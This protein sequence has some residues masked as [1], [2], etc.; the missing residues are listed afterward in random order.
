MVIPV[1]T[2]KNKYKSALPPFAEM[3]LL[4]LT[5]I[6]FSWTTVFC[7]RHLPLIDFMPWKVGKNIN[8]TPSLPVR[9]F[10]TYKNRHS[11]E[12]KEFVAPDYPWNDSTW[13]SN[14]IFKSQRVEDPNLNQGIILR[15]EDE[16]GNIVTSSIIQNPS[17]QF[18][19][20]AYDLSKADPDGFLKILPFYKLAVADNYSFLCLTSTLPAEVRKF[21]I[22]HGTS[23]KYLFADDVVLKTMV[24]ANPGLILLKNGVV[25]AKWHY[26]DIPPYDEVR[27]KYMAK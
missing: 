19:V 10:V 15:V 25:L 22:A 5:V 3:L 6:S 4:F 16:N 26:N 23:Y 13:L 2:W 9:F 11:G 8:Q 27:R 17:F 24:R 14:W 7:L 21:R 20:V 12:E 18:I 1:F